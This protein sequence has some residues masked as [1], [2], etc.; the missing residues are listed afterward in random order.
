[1]EK[2]THDWYIA[3]KLSYVVLGLTVQFCIRTFMSGLRAIELAHTSHERS[4]LGYT[5]RR[6]FVIYF[7]RNLGGFHPDDD[8]RPKSD[9][10]FTSLLGLLELWSYPVLMATGAWTVIGAWLGFK[11][12]A[13]YKRW[14]DDRVSFVLYLIGNALIVLL[15]LLVLVP[16]VK[17]TPVMNCL[18]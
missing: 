10:W 2:L 8:E 3:D 6:R 1:M 7:W 4:W 18:P 9:F 5:W 12:V 14:N 13:Q 16:Y 17:I 11:T 15:S